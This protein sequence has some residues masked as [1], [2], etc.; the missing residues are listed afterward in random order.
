MPCP[1]VALRSALYAA[2]AAQKAAAGYSNNTFEIVQTQL[3][4]YSLP[5]LAETPRVTVIGLGGDQ[6][7]LSRDRLYQTEQPVQVSLQ[8]ALTD[9]ADVAQIDPLIELTDELMATARELA[10][11]RWQQT[12]SLKDENG[13]PYDYV[14]LREASTYEAVFTAVYHYT[15][16]IE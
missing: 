2:I 9:P 5:E 7:L 15:P 11:W 3:P 12:R 4:S 8:A 14:R 10:G 1:M 6:E 16:E 13:T